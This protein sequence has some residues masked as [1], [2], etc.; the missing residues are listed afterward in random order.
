MTVFLIIAATIFLS[1]CTQTKIDA[2]GAQSSTTGGKTKKQEHK[3]PNDFRIEVGKYDVVYA[4]FDGL[5][6]K[7]PLPEK[8]QENVSIER[9]T[10]PSGVL[11]HFVIVYKGKDGK[12]GPAVGN[13]YV[14][15]SEQW[16]SMSR[17]EQSQAG[18]ELTTI[19]G[20][21]YVYQ[22]PDSNPFKPDSAEAK[23]FESRVVMMDEAKNLLHIFRQDDI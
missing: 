22:S 20:S 12:E 23:A 3:S 15:D 19:D 14:F 10:L 18:L 8:W 11:A 6:T 9:G 5:G 16:N 21:R 2:T 13:L 17:D 4:A 7:M 1:G